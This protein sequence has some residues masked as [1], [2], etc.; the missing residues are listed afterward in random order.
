VFTAVCLLGAVSAR[1]P[2]GAPALVPHGVEA[3]G[4]GRVL[5]GVGGRGGGVRDGTVG[6]VVTTPVAEPEPP[7][8]NLSLVDGTH[9]LD[10]SRAGYYFRKAQSARGQRRWV[11][12]MEGGGLC[13]DPG[14][15][16][17]RSHTNL[18][19][20][21]NWGANRTGGASLAVD[22]AR[23]PDFWDANHLFVPYC[24]GDLSVLRA[25]LLAPLLC[26]R[27]SRVPPVSVHVMVVCHPPPPPTTATTLSHT[28][29]SS[30]R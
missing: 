22:S 18:G 7:L 19:S 12:Y 25:P 16:K 30:Q 13:Y 4:V 14:S 9:C 29:F 6:I 8:M 28:R 20:S 21:E 27:L 5:P 24:T 17:S 26:R 1:V 15:C 10:G 3:D 2:P 11:V 23:N